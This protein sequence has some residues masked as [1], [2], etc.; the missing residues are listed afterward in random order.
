MRGVRVDDFNAT[1]CNVSPVCRSVSIS[2]FILPSL[3]SVSF[4]LLPF[5]FL[6]LYPRFVLLVF[7]EEKKKKRKKESKR[8]AADVFVYSF[9]SS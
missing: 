6:L 7:D 1:S 8:R 3:L 2:I 9:D 4:H 5:F